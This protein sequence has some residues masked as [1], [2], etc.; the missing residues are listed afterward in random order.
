MFVDYGYPSLGGA[1]M[2]DQLRLSQYAWGLFQY[3]S[4]YAD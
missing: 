1:L 3:G 2:P 4:L